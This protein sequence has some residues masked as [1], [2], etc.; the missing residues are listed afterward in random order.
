MCEKVGVS[1]F[2]C[3]RAGRFAVNDHRRHSV[4]VQ[5]FG[6]FGDG[7]IMHVEYADFSSRGGY[8]MDQGD[9]VFV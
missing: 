6:P 3:A 7:G 5:L 8:A 9:G 4:D 2:F 1:L